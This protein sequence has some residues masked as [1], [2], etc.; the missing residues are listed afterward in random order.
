MERAAVQVPGDE[1]AR[2][3]IAALLSPDIDST[4]S[5]G[6][7]ADGVPYLSRAPLVSLVQSH[8]EE[9]LG[10]AGVPDPDEHW[11]LLSRIVGTVERDLHIAPGSFTPDDPDWYVYIAEGVLER[12]ADGNASFNQMR[13]TFLGGQVLGRYSRVDL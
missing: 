13:K 2:D 11:G 9:A 1:P 6:G 5:S 10:E 7:E 3:K 4:V 8:L 12:L